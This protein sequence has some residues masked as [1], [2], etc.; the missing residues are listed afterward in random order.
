MQKILH[1]LFS[2]SLDEKC[3]YIN[4][5]NKIRLTKGDGHE[6]FWFYKIPNA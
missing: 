1:L 5:L 3:A 6:E 4:K 2:D